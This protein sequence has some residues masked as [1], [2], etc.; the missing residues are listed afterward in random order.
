[1]KEFGEEEGNEWKKTKT[2]EEEKGIG[3]DRRG[4]EVGERGERMKEE[5][6][7]KG[8]GTV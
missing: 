6:M 1:M 7:D 4:S 8:R 3:E 2:I 5:T